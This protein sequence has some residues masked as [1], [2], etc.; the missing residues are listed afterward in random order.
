M[1]QHRYRKKT[2]FSFSV[3]AGG[4]D[5]TGPHTRARSA[6]FAG[7]CATAGFAANSRSAGR[8]STAADSLHLGQA[9]AQ[10]EPRRV[11]QGR[12]ASSALLH[13]LLI[14]SAHTHTL[15]LS[16]I[17]DC[18]ENTVSVFKC[19][20]IIHSLYVFSIGGNIL[21][22]TP[23]RL[24]SLLDGGSEGDSFHLVTGVKSLEWLV[25]DE[26]DRLLEFGFKNS[27]VPSITFS[28][29]FLTYH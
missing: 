28:L 14:L 6:G 26:A 20:E 7:G 22:C 16:L 11:Q 25:L 9:D 1:T 10:T 29:P 21:V 17:V 15:S 18:F 3:S 4:S 13:C 27:Y 19:L 8:F 12:S 24:E 23:G 2:I 5:N